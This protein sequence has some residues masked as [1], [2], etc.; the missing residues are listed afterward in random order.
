MSQPARRSPTRRNRDFD[1][2]FPSAPDINWNAINRRPAAPAAFGPTLTATVKWFNP[3][4]GF[5]FVAMG[6]GSGDAFLHSAVLRR[7]GYEA[8]GEGATLQVRVGPGQKGSQV[9]EV[10]SVDETT[11]APASARPAR[12]P[13]GFGGGGGGRPERAAPS[14]PTVETTGTV[15]WFNPTKGFGFIAPQDGGKDIF[16]HVSAL[17]GMATLNE[18]QQVRVSVRQGAKG[19]EAG[20]VYID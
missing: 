13:G 8:V 14:G 18:G 10:V 15:K 19:P 9:T 20:R 4:K 1:D 16:V 12:A 17:G 7:A 11:A 2:D 6:D 3:E 5:G